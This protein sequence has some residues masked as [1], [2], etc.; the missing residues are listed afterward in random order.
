MMRMPVSPGCIP[1]WHSNGGIE[2]STLAATDL[3]QNRSS[4]KRLL[5]EDI[6]RFEEV[7]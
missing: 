2:I 6:T 1:C 4:P 3:A 5:V 7:R